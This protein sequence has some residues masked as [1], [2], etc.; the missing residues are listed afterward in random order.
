VFRKQFSG[1]ELQQ[2]IGYGLIGGGQTRRMV[3]PVV[4]PQSGGRVEAQFT[5]D[6]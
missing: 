1:P 4:L 2:T 6:A 5:P 3:L